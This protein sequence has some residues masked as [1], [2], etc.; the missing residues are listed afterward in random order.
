[1]ASYKNRLA[2]AAIVDLP[3][4]KRDYEIKKLQLDALA[5]SSP[6]MYDERIDGG[7]GD[8]SIDRYLN[9]YDDPKLRLLKEL[10]DGIYAAYCLL[11][12]H[13]RRVLALKCWRG[14]EVK[15]IS[16]ELGFSISSIYRTVSIAL[17]KLYF[18]I[19]QIKDGLYDWRTGRLK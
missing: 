12:E 15:A 11:D 17:H 3:K 13:E 18:P 19:S 10:I 7:G 5:L 14:L 2:E 6:C 16:V 1:M 9:R 4:I 8:A